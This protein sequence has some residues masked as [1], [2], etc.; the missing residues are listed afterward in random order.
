V[1]SQE[2]RKRAG[3]RHERAFR[4][5]ST[6]TDGCPRRPPSLRTGRSAEMHEDTADASNR[7]LVRI[8][9]TFSNEFRLKNHSPP[10]A[11]SV[12]I[13]SCVPPGRAAINKVI[14]G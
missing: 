9:H 3:N 10:S 1:V 5:Q 14:N 13:L 2:P 11:R 4:G 7:P 12:H 8:L 6:C